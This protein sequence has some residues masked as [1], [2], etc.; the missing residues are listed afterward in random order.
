VANIPIIPG[1]KPFEILNRIDQKKIVGLT[2]EVEQLAR[3]RKSRMEKFKLASKDSYSDLK[4][5]QKEI[6]YAESIY[7][8]SPD[9]PVVEV[10]NKSIEEIA[11]EVIIA[12]A[13]RN[14]VTT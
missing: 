9:W 13:Q 11:Q 2:I 1:I 4:S 10:T 8:A 3:I 7:Q 12:L 5:V 6:A 14:P